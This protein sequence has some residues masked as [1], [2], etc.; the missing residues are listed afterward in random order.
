MTREGQVRLLD[1]GIAKLV[2]DGEA[3][4][5]ELTQRGGRALTRRS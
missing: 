3:L 1:F 5:T 4:E 2:T